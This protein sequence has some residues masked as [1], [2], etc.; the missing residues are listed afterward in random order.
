MCPAAQLGR[1]GAGHVRMTE[2]NRLLV[3]DASPL[4]GL[5]PV[6]KGEILDDLAVAK[7]ETIGKSCAN[8]MGRVFHADPDMEVHHHFVS[9]HQELLGVAGPF[10][11]S[12][13]SFRDVLLHFRNTTIGAGCWKAL[14]LNAHNFRIKILGDG[15]HVIAIDCSEE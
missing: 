1:Q 10:G 6:S 11:P 7:D 8:P 4:E 2:S 3:F 14:G 15:L 5:R 9:I 13:T 12:P